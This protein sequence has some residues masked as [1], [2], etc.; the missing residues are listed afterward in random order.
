M[1]RG[2]DEIKD[3]KEAAVN[4]GKEE[5]ICSAEPPHSPLLPSQALDS[6]LEISASTPSGKAS[7]SIPHHVGLFRT[8]GLSFYSPE[9][10]FFSQL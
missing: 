4:S 6:F 5:G 9:N 2:E 10:L 1:T 7:F 3:L 8:Y